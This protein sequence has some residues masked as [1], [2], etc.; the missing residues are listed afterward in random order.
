MIKK[1]FAVALLALL[2][3]FA[4]PTVANAAGYGD[5]GDNAGT[6]V[7]A[8]GEAVTF[9]FGG[10]D[11]FEQT[12]ASA[13][14]QV[15]LSSLKVV[16]TASKPADAAGTVQYTAKATAPGSY[17]ITVTGT[18]GA[19]RTGVLTVAPTDSGAGTGSGTNADGSLPNTGLQ[20]PMLIVWGATGALVLGAALVFV[21]MVV[22]RNKAA[23]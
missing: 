19:I 3:I 17:T 13:P 1:F 20:T 7:A 23:A 12:V 4:V 6:V 18:N 8:P 10:F 11:A 5:A 21:L 16:V 2:S 22:R 15:T 14:D 9:T